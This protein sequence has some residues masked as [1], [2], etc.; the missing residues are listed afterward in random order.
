MARKQSKFPPWE[1]FGMIM[2]VIKAVMISIIALTV[3]GISFGIFGI[4]GFTAFAVG[5]IIAAII[6]GYINGIVAK[7][8]YEKILKNS[9]YKSKAALKLIFSFILVFAILEFLLTRDIFATTMSIIIAFI[10]INITI[11][12]YDKLKWALPIGG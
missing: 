1:K 4:F 5:L 11:K 10:A 3:G 9:F 2:S 7:I 12:I 6:L 8:T